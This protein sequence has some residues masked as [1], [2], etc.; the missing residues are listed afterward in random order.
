[1]SGL[2]VR[3]RFLFMVCYCNSF[4]NLCD[5]YFIKRAIERDREGKSQK[6]NFF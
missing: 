1:M 2:K 6:S 3:V 4:F 5:L